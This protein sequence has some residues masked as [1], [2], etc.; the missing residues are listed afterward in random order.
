MST[1]KNDADSS[2]R[3]RSLGSPTD[4]K[5]EEKR[6]GP[7]F[8]KEEADDD[9]WELGERG[10]TERLLVIP[11]PSISGG[12]KTPVFLLLGLIILAMAG[13]FGRSLLQQSVVA[14]LPDVTVEPQRAPIAPPA[15]S[16]PEAVREPQRAPIAP[17]LTPAPEVAREPQ[18]APIAPPVP[19]PL[20]FTHVEPRAEAVKIVEGEILTF[21][22]QASGAA[23]LQ[24]EW[25]LEGK[26]VSQERQWSY[27][28]AAGEGAG[29]KTVRVIVSDQ[30]DQHLERE[31]RVAVRSPEPFLPPQAVAPPAPPVAPPLPKNTPPHIAQ[32]FPAESSLIVHPGETIEFSALALDPDE[33]T[34]SYEW[35]VNGKPVAQGEHFSYEV[36]SAGKYSIGLTASDHGGLKDTARWEV[37]V[38]TPPSPPRLAMYTPHQ[39]QVTFAAHFTRF[40]GVEVETPGSAEPPLHYEWRIDNRFAGESELLEWKNHTP[41]R[42]TVDVTVTGASG[43]SISHRWIVNVQE[44]QELD[45]QSEVG[46]PRLTVA[47]LENTIS[48][49]KTQVVVKGRLQNVGERTVENIIAWVSALDAQQRTVSR[50]L[51]LPAPQPLA[52]G[53]EA[54]FQTAFLN[55]GEIVDFHVEVVSK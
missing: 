26:R 18:R 50:R 42:H 32:R 10:K 7:S 30:H 36:G 12:R 46:P 21:T 41:G 49:D 23:P 38:V 3:L 20:T 43:A 9:H 4:L 2:S 55:R 45:E 47:E 54:A 16:A 31:W 29:E 11:A 53:Q 14:P 22:A 28:P 51:A 24:Y 15:A 25:R 19:P 37:A 13:W 1:E 6:Q 35:F 52:P 5:G 34:V 48:A 33:E 44:K 27:H 8:H 39:D 17:P 40:F